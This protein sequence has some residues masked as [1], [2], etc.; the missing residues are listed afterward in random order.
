VAAEAGAPLVAGSSLKAA[1][2]LDWDALRAQ[3]QA[4]YAPG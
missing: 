4:P 3:Q 2:D 1:L